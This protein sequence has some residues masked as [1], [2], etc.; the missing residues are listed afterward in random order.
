MLTACPLAAHGDEPV[1]SG[2]STEAQRFDAEKQRLAAQKEKQRHGAIL[3]YVLDARR[4]A[5]RAWKAWHPPANGKL[6]ITRVKVTIDANGKMAACKIVTPSASEQE[7]KSIQEC[8]GMVAFG[9]MRA[10]SIGYE[11]MPPDVSSLN[12]FWTMMSNGNMNMNWV[13]FTDSRE[14][15]DYNANLL[16][17]T[18]PAKGYGIY[19]NPD[20]NN[21]ERGRSSASAHAD[22]D[23]GPYMADMQKRVKRAWFPPKGAESKRVV[24]QFKIRAGGEL[25][26]LRI[27]HSSGLAIADQSALKAVENAAPFAPLPAGAQKELDVQFIF[28]GNVFCGRCFFH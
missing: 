26:N 20:A 1:S 15:N 14:A 19:G 24:V 25:S 6:L 28:D 5:D 18:I 16:G 21:N 2:E 23:F 12:C 9:P 17:E 22:V 13:E 11:P 10:G 8:L 3:K 4:T 27:D 7:D